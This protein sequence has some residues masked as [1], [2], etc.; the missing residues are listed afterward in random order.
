MRFLLFILLSVFSVVS[1]AT[2][3]SSVYWI[4]YGVSSDRYPSASAA[5]AAWGGSILKDFS[6]A[7]ADA[8]YCHWS[9]GYIGVVAI[10]SDGPCPDGFTRD[11]SKPAYDSQAC[12]KPDSN[13]PPDPPSDCASRIGQT[14]DDYFICVNIECPS[15]FILGSTGGYTCNP[16]SSAIFRSVSPPGVIS[17]AGCKA[18]LT[19]N[20]L[21]N[22]LV[23]ASVG[24]LAADQYCHQVYT[25]TGE[26]FDTANDGPPPANSSSP[27]PSG[28]PSLDPS[29]SS[30]GP[31]TAGGDSG[32]GSGGS[33]GGNNGGTSGTGDG[34]NAP[35]VPT[36]ENPCTQTGGGSYNCVPTDINPCTG[37]GNA[38]TANCEASPVCTGDA[39][40]CGQL[41]QTWKSVCQVHKDLTE[42][43]DATQ[44]K[45]DQLK[46]ADGSNDLAFA[47]ASGLLDLHLADF[48]AVI[49]SEP[50]GQCLTD[51]HITVLTASITIPLSEICAFL[52]FL[53]ML[54]HLGVDYIALRIVARAISGG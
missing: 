28:S 21:T 7:R 34:T 33:S 43:D 4:K 2:E 54:L 20:E 47:N 45:L 11:A 41:I 23:N 3:Y 17:V 1:A 44:Q 29:S 30:G 12:F 42:I 31:G 9:G 37:V 36:A 48:E 24:A 35:C 13:P 8:K 32:L 38:Q 39:V 14:E 40:Q 27:P 25:V 16:P 10:P 26:T 5:C 46:A 51:I 49:G 15:G 6:P 52:T 18:V 19:S 50:S 22:N 53:K